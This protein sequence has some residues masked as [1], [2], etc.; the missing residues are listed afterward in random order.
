ME[1]IFG[2]RELKVSS[3]HWQGIDR[4]GDGLVGEAV[5]D[6]GLVEAVTLAGS[7]SPV[8]AVQWHP[9]WFPNDPEVPG[10]LFRQ[11][12]M[13]FE[14]GIFDPAIRQFGQLLD[15]YPTLTPAAL[16]AVKNIH[17]TGI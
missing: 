5:A 15:S 3:L 17:T 12:R 14:R 13:Y 11:G 2:R 16:R 7:A 6:D 4:L 10:I 9:E 8:M 1:S